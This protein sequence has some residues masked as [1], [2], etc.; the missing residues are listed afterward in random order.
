MSTDS[1]YY[2]YNPE[3]RNIFIETH[4][5]RENIFIEFIYI[6]FGGFLTFASSIV[7]VFL[8]RQFGER[9]FTLSQSIIIFISMNLSYAFLKYIYALFQI[10]LDK[11][12]WFLLFVFSCVYLGFSIYHRREIRKYGTAYDFKRFSKSNGLIHPLWYR[13]IDKKVLNIKITQYLVSVLLEPAVPVII[14]LIL[15]PFA[16]T[17]IVGAILIFSGF[18]FGLKNFQM[19]QAGR[20]WV[21]DNID[22]KISNEMQYDVFV[23]RK[24][25]SETKGVYLPIELPEDEFTRMALYKAVEESNGFAHD[26]WENDN[27]DDE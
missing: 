16:W 9:Y 27:L 17:G 2:K 13:I 6:I 1:Q 24:P 25:K 19:A 22:K 7:E 4:S 21:L 10:R 20:N 15:L 18:C 8:R 11:S 23:G 3:K 14:G 26:I 12:G 5:G